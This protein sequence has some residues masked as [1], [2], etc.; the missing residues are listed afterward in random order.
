MERL[1]MPPKSIRFSQKAR[2]QLALLKR[3]TKIEHFNVLA[4]WAICTSLAEKAPA[5]DAHIPSDSNLEMA[6][7]VF[8][9]RHAETIW[10]LV[11]QRCRDEGLPLTDDECAKQLRLHLHRGISYLAGDRRMRSIEALLETAVA[12]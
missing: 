7:D 8:G 11:K 4:R 12:K 2:D 5:P 6:W 9:G 1:P 10:A 3:Y